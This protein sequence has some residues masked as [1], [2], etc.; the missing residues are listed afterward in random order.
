MNTH[1]ILL[2]VQYITIVVLF[3]E[4]LIVFMK[5]SNPIHSYFFFACISSFISNM[6]Y[7]LEMKAQTEEAYI[8]ALQLSYV[9]RVFIVLAFFLF[10]AKMCKVKLPKWL[11]AALMLVHIGIYVSILMVGSCGLYYSGYE[12][13]PDPVFPRF[14]HENGPLHDLLMAMNG[15]LACT[16]F[17]WV[18]RVYRKEKNRTAKSRFLMLIL[19]FGIQILS[20]FLHITHVFKVSQYFDLTMPGALFGTIFMLI[21]ILGFDLLG[22]NEIA[23]LFAIDRISEGIIAVDNEGRV[24]Y[25]NEP[26][27]KLYPELD[28][29]FSRKKRFNEKLH[30]TEEP[31]RIG[32]VKTRIYTPYDII[33]FITDAVEKGETL[34]IG[35]RIYTPEENDLQYKG[36]SYGKLY[37]LVD[38]T[39]HFRYMEELQEQRDIADSANEAKSRFLA[40]M[41]HEIRT[42]INA[43]LG[44]DE[45]ILRESNEKEIRAYASDIMSASRTLLSLI[46]DIL[47]LSKVEEGKMEI[48]PVQYDLSSLIND[49]VNMIRDRAANKGLNF[50]VNVD[51]HIP[52]LLLGDEIRIR[53]CAMNLLTNAVKYT[54]SGWVT[55]SLSFKKKSDDH[56]LLG[57]TVGDTGIGM[58]EEDMENLFS[59]YKRIE[60]KRNRSIEG[61]GLGMS[62]T[63]QLLDLMD[64]SLS[65]HSEYGKGSVFSFEIDQ[66]VLKWEEI[67]DY[68]SRFGEMSERTYEYH[69]L[70][71]APDAR[72]LVVDDTEMNLT[73][74][75]SLLKKTGIR[76]DTATSGREALDLTT[77][78]AYDLVFID[79]MM[80]D[81]DGIE[82]L[83]HIRESGKCTEVPAIALTAN[84][85]SGAREMY[86]AAGFTD[87]LSKPVDGEKLEK[88]L[89]EKIPDEKILKGDEDAAY[90]EQMTAG[91]SGTSENGT[92]GS[93]PDGAGRMSMNGSNSD[94]A[95]SLAWLNAVSEIDAQSGLKNCGSEEG[96]VSVLSVF[97]QTAG[98]KADEIETLF[99]EGDIENYTIKVHALKSSARII[100]A[101]SLSEF[102]KD[103]EEAGKRNDT[104]YIES[105]TAKLLEMYRFL[106]SAL[107]PLDDNGEDLPSIDEN[108]L[109]EA[110]QTIIEIAGSMDFGFMEDILKDLRGY[111]LP[112]PDKDRITKI[113][114]RLTELDWDGIIDLAKERI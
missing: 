82:T 84:A 13:I 45:M 114:G 68:S 21:G 19:A 104:E 96:Y 62:I 108:S 29:F 86:L 35:D 80:P 60:E 37:A 51:E 8:S 46:N 38:D 76:I 79:H 57:F 33:S 65:V 16:A 67:G 103:L 24:Q 54:G 106:D 34:K 73:V 88:L 91:G 99:R 15:V 64:S 71:H 17:C 70:F 39:E 93:A 42:P 97:H 5:W 49:L 41:S 112:T 1:D 107:S 23:R 7:L 14:V 25:Y 61:T 56:I 78:K 12:F 3:I 10:S 44:M 69:E 52:H 53:Q 4:I 36:E 94:G 55:L 85:V 40:N 102:A 95:G 43:V 105:N 22:T 90:T 87:Y 59:P 48:I 47:D 2:A 72:I 20:F 89:F 101:A 50:S 83:Q 11:I 30:H 58:K 32:T 81:M 113:E 111:S 6:G 28:A 109:R 74:I 18:F 100:G 77:Q 98:S 75:Q 110:Y 92:E 31:A 27:A 26:A 9:G 63:R 66:E